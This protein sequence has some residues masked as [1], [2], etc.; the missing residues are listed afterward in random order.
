MSNSR[1]PSSSKDVSRTQSETILEPP[2]SKGK[3]RSGPRRKSKA[4]P[5]NEREETRSSAGGPRQ[6]SQ[7]KGKMTSE[8]PKD[9]FKEADFIAFDFSDEE[10]SVEESKAAV[11]KWDKGKEKA[12]EVEDIHPGRKRKAEE[13]DRND[14]YAN[15]KQR[16]A[17]PSRRA[18]WATDVDWDSCTNVA[19]MLH[20]DVEAYVKYI[21]PTPEEDEIRSLVVTLIARSVTQAFPD[22]Q[23]VPFGSYETKM[24]L[25][26]GDIDLVIHSQSM[27]YSNKETV[28][29]ALANTMKRSEITERVNI[30]A[31]AKVPIIKF[32]THYGRFSVDISINQGNGVSAGKMIKQFLAEMPALRSL[33][34]VIKSFL[35]QRSMNEV[36]SGGLGSYSIVCMAI[37]F[38]QMHPKIRRG[39]I[40]PL[41]NLGVLV[42]EFFELYGY[43]FNYQ[44]VGI[45]IR[46]GGS[47]YNKTERGWF[48]RTRPKLLSVEDPGDPSNDVSRGSYSM[49][50]VRTTLAGA[51][52]IMT[53]AAYM[54]AGVISAKRSGRFVQ[55]RDTVNPEEFSILASVM[56]VTQETI[57]HRRLVQELYDSRALHRLLGV[58][59][60]AD[61][62]GIKAR[63]T[64]NSEVQRPR[65][66]DIDTALGEADMEEGS[67][68][69]EDGKIITEEGSRYKIEDRRQPPRKRRK[70]GREEDMHTVFT[71]DDED[72]EI[73]HE[74]EEYAL[75]GLEDGEEEE[76]AA[77]LA[78]TKYSMES[79]AKSKNRRDFW[80][81]KGS[82][83]VASDS[84]DD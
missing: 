48:D 65:Q 15:R 80:L 66:E 70:M 56:G 6:A 36:F 19:D 41:K 3:H 77:A 61:I 68:D 64:P 45:S 39:E 33:V 73:R 67:T 38:L 54:R 20:R 62:A 52:S 35:A 69:N 40:D 75:E 25:P 60:S 11:R 63:P 79:S 10:E 2:Q 53:A 37:S 30:I 51:H 14:P 9:I 43:Y 29:H 84:S 47:Y 59:A 22:A 83:G 13:F 46:D 1:M 5:S 42:M 12:R 26:Q 31:R 55:L 23:I 18:P 24:Y 58:N 49:F 32:V 71:T 28:L 4:S 16:F 57:N 17:A 81:S 44:E 8:K 21:S 50:R 72:G 7:K 27:A 74:Y 78:D 76:D 34:L 82:Q